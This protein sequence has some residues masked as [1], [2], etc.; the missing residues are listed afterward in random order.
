[1]KQNLFKKVRKII[2]LI[3]QSQAIS[4]K[5]K[6]SHKNPIRNKSRP[7][8]KSERTAASTATAKTLGKL[9]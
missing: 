6:K 3:K 7:A 2:T 9:A 8:R 5:K 1:M 4:N